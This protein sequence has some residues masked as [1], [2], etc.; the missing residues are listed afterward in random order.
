VASKTRD[1]LPKV[2]LRA[3]DQETGRLVGIFGV[4]GAQPVGG[5]CLISASKVLTCLHVVR[6]ALGQ[7]PRKGDSIE[8][9]PVGLTQTC[10]LAACVEVVGD[11]GTPGNDIALLT[12]RSVDIANFNVADVEFATPFR[13]EGKSFSVMGFPQGDPQGRHA[14]GFLHA[15]DALGLI[16]MD[17]DSR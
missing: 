2:L 14:R 6:L 13:H 5:G 1:I 7:E 3:T 10:R 12:L 8:V 4:G 17:I 9:V 15:A 11:E 16:Q